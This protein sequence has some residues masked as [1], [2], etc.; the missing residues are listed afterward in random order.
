MDIQVKQID[1]PSYEEWRDKYQYFYETEIMDF[2]VKAA[3]ISEGAEN[4]RATY[5]IGVS[6]FENPTNFYTPVLFYDYV[7]C[8]RHDD[9]TR[10]FWYDHAIKQAQETFRNH[11]LSY[12]E[13]AE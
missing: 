2:H 6:V 3:C 12:L 5:A 13:V 8:C 10:K 4:L 1:F 7:S 9:I 11:I